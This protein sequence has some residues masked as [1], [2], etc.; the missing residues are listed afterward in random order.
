MF[1]LRY[2]LR[3]LRL[4]PSFAVIAVLILAVGIGA[5]VAVFSVVDTLVLKPL[6]FRDAE[7]LVWIINSDTPGLSG[8]THRVS[9]YEAL[10]PM[11]SLEDITTY[12]AFFARSSYKLTGD[13]EPDRVAGVMVPANF[14]SFLGVEPMLGRTFLPEEMSLSGP[15]AVMLSHGLWERRYSSDPGVVG[16]AMRV[17]DRAVTIVGVLPESF[18]FGEVFAPGVNIEVFMPA[19]FEELRDWGN[20]MAIL[21]RLQPGMTLAAA[22][23]EATA[24]IE[25]QQLDRPDLGGGPG[26]YHAILQPF[27][28]SVVGKIREPMLILWAAVGLVLLIV[29]VNLSNL[30]LARAATRRKEM[31]LRCAIG[32]GRLRLARQ[33]L[34][35]SLA[36]SLLGGG[37]G[38][39]LAY[40]LVGSIRR[41]EGLSIPLLHSVAI[42]AEALGV[43]VGVTVLTAVLFGLAPAF[44]VLRGDINDALKDNG[45]SAGEGRDHRLLRASLVVS[46][47]ALACLLLIGAGLLLRSFSHLLDVNLG[48][49]PERTYALR[50][51]AGNDIN[52]REKF[53]AYIRQLITAAESVPGITASVTDAVPLDSNRSWGVRRQDQTN[54]EH[55][56]ALVKVIGPGLME[57]MR[58]PILAG[59]EFTDGDDYQREDV[60]LINETL[61]R[62]LW[63]NEEAV[64]K[65]LMSGDFQRRVVGV[66]ADVRHLSVE[67][68]A[69]PEFYIA[70]LQN[71][72]GSPSL[73]VRTTRPFADVAPALR[74]ALTQVVP[75]LPT[76]TFR[77]I[78]QLVER[79]MS[80]RRFF[81]NLLMAFAAAALGLAAIGIYGVISY[82]VARRTPEIG[83]RMALGASAGRVRAGVVSDTLRLALLGVA[84]GLPAAV[85]LSSLMTSLL[86]GVSPMDPW[87]FAAAAAVLLLVAF[88]AGLLPAS[89]ASRISPM[90]AM[91]TE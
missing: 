37:L 59:R 66:V 42:N 86:F 80:P 54:E 76:G 71:G 57:T 28:E 25:R 56:G 39:A 74:T 16:S 89:R 77:P 70:L 62:R 43:A 46:E 75:D 5:N 41:I 26:S 14:F 58:T 84:I 79:A 52:S 32:A 82:S 9:T 85:A 15:G 8:R 29:C 22:Q 30:L 47:V 12:E 2:A 13:L 40:F 51:D 19:P 33:T 63:P 6:P 61:A 67:E 90:A 68:P 20:T 36:L 27:R 87:T 31:A 23:A 35:E 18:D 53:A 45:R 21:G 24:L 78:D 88:A 4:Q 72:S 55:I 60:T 69:G 11:R 10:E 38:V 73:V 91:R 50:I 3:Q 49:E 44:S 64:G 7:R 34:T 1:D 17:N 83:I 65:I 81:L 48:F